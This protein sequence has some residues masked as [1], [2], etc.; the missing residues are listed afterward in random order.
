MH[1]MIEES[2]QFNL[3]FKVYLDWLYNKLPENNILKIS[4]SLVI[5]NA[6]QVI[7]NKNSPKRRAQHQ[8]VSFSIASKQN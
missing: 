7:K 6:C 2:M 8:M 3:I 4:I 1:E 5:E